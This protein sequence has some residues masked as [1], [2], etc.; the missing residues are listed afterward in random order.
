MGR[1]G[2]QVANSLISRSLGGLL[3]GNSAGG[4]WR[5]LGEKSGLRRQAGDLYCFQ[6]V[7]GAAVGRYSLTKKRLR[8]TYTT[9]SITTQITCRKVFADE[10]AIETVMSR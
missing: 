10:E 9:T 4:T 5:K 1:D 7:G 8:P 2:W 3:R 6:R